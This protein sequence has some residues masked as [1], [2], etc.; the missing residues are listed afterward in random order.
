M[1]HTKLKK[2]CTKNQSLKKPKHGYKKPKKKR[3]KKEA[4]KP[5]LRGCAT[6]QCLI[7]AEIDR[8]QS[9]NQKQSTRE[10]QRTKRF[11]AK[12]FALH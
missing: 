1:H 10:R 11:E 9:S 12:A 6:D 4:F 8:S 7:I 5:S 3:K 2:N